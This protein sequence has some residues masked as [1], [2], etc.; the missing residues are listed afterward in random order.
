MSPSALSL[1]AAPFEPR[2]LCREPT[3]QRT[4]RAALKVP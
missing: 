1:V 3:I 2:M 4:G